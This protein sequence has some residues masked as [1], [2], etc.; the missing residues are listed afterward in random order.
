MIALPTQLDKLY[1]YEQGEA[2]R[3]INAFLKKLYREHEAV[4]TE[5]NTVFCKEFESEWEDLRE[6]WEGWF[7]EENP[8]IEEQEEKRAVAEESTVTVSASVFYV[9]E[10]SAI[11]LLVSGGA[12][13]VLG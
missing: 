9:S 12:R 13:H 4:L 6:I 7:L 11:F 5:A 10:Y 1:L 2:D 8:D 3:K